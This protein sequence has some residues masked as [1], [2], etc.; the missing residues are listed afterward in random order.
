MSLKI[1]L[2]WKISFKMENL[3]R[4]PYKTPSPRFR[5]RA[6]AK[7]ETFCSELSENSLLPILSLEQ[8]N[9]FE[10]KQMCAKSKKSLTPDCFALFVVCQ[11]TIRCQ[12]MQFEVLCCFFQVSQ[13]AD[14]CQARKP[15]RQLVMLNNPLVC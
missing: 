12:Y 15:T 14:L 5:L 7:R 9:G 1:S 3:F 13:E 2:R 11:L 10:A 6:T 4:V 8:V